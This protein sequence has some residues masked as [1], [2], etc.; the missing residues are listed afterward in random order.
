MSPLCVIIA[1]TP[2]RKGK[3]AVNAHLKYIQLLLFALEPQY[4]IVNF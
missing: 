4:L 2:Q 1:Q 3:P